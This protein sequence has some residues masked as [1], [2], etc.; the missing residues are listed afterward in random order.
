MTHGLQR[1]EYGALGLCALCLA[2]LAACGGGDNTANGPKETSLEGE[3]SE[4]RPVDHTPAVDLGKAPTD[5]HRVLARLLTAKALI[6]ESVVYGGWNAAAADLSDEEP[7]N[8]LMP[9][10]SAKYLSTGYTI[11]SGGDDNKTATQEYP[12]SATLIIVQAPDAQA[13][14]VI[15]RGIYERLLGVRFERRDP[16]ELAFGK[17]EGNQ[18]RMERY[19]RIDEG[20][21]KDTVLVGYIAVIGDLVVYALEV[22]TPPRIVG[23]GQTQIQ[24]VTNDQRGTRVGAQ[25]IAMV[26]HLRG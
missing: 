26:H 5:A 9:C 15:A 22:E 12:Q 14:D 20:S 23:P 7:A 8:A 2:L 25:L 19:L 4:R 1:F 6:R 11:E 13:T 24:R 3:R 16:V 17:G 18:L 10:I 21:D